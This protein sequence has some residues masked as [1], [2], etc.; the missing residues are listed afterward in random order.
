MSNNPYTLIR[1]SDHSDWLALRNTGIGGSDAGVILGVNPF[2]SLLS[3]WM[4]KTG[5]K[6]PDDLSDNSAVYWGS[7][8][9]HAIRVHVIKQHP[10]WTI[11]NKNTM[12]KSDTHPFMIAN[13]DGTVK[14]EQGRRGVLEIKTAGGYSAKYWDNGVPDYYMAQVMH[15]LAVTGWDFAL[16]AVLIGG[17][18]YREYIIERDEEDIAALIELEEK[19]WEMVTSKTEPAIS[20]MSCDKA[21]LQQKHPASN[22]EYLAS[23]EQDEELFEK[24]EDIKAQIKALTNTKSELENHLKQVIGDNAGLLTPTHKITWTRTQSTT[25]DKKALEADL[26]DK[27]AKYQKSSLKD[28]GLRA[29]K[30][31]DV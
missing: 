22:G 25:L 28:M 11:R 26:G 8:L 30:R 19:F 9:E 13:L 27:L 4:E 21:Y 6:E 18:D 12:L 10:D 20:G 7:T 23:T 15:Y 3:L 1:Y 5:I 14:D 31:K 29:S 16:V 24:L 2:K 17:Q